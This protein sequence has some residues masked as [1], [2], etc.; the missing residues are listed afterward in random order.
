MKKMMSALVAVAFA[1]GSAFAADQATKDAAK[2]QADQ[3]RIEE[4]HKAGAQ[5]KQKKSSSSTKSTKSSEGT[6]KSE[7]APS[8]PPASK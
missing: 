2:G 6:S 4:T 7:T 5:K 3:Q 8:T 1:S